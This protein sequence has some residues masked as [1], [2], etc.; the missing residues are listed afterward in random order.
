M[1]GKSFRCRIGMHHWVLQHEPES[2]GAF[3]ECSR[4]G[5]DRSP[6]GPSVPPV[7]PG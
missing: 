2:G 5:K 6:D 7:V 4:C 1:D 3:Y